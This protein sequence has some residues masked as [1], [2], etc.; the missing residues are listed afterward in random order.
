MDIT[1]IAFNDF[2]KIKKTDKEE[3]VFEIQDEP[4]YLNHL[5]TVHASAQFALAEATSGQYLLEVFEEYMEKGVIPVVR[6]VEVKYKKP[7]KGAI[8]SHAAMNDKEIGK[9][10]D[11]LN[12]KGRALLDVIVKVY[13]S[14]NEVTMLSK[15]TWFLLI[16][17]STF[18]V[19]V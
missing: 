1:K 13:D 10:K 6:S 9:V 14:D 7:A 4:Q 5:E 8:F 18:P 3:Y 12:V 2:M 16:N 11:N 15:F 19:E 17:N